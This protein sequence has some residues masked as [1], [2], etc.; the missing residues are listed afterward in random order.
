M[1]ETGEIKMFTKYFETQ[2]GKS[3]KDASEKEIYEN[4]ISFTEEKAKERGANEGKKKLYYISAEFL[5]GKLLINNLINLGLYDSVD[6][7]LSAVG[8]SLSE[9][10]DIEHEP[11]L[12]NGG[13]GRLA[14]CFMDS[15]ATLGLLADGVGLCYHCG[16]FA[17]E[18]LKNKQSEK[19]DYWINDKTWL[20]KSPLSFEVKFK[21]FCLTSILYD[22]CVTGYSNKSNRLRLFDIENADEKIIKNGIDFNKKD[23]K[24]NLTLFLYPDDSDDDGKKLR[25]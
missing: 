9:I 3:L 25:V 19:P 5:I 17:Q 24:R 6:K 13:L 4:L 12:G 7:E 16:L 21:D 2:T 18:F 22:L 11:S 15:A 20:K 8:K 14:A 23:I 10:E 1:A